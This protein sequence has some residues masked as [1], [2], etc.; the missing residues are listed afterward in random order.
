MMKITFYTYPL[1]LG[2]DFFPPQNFCGTEIFVICTEFWGDVGYFVIVE[3][4]L[5]L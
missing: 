1:R 5:H 2:Q 3:T 4:S